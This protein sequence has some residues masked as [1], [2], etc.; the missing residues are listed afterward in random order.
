MGFDVE[1]PIDSFG[2]LVADPSWSPLR[3][4][5]LVT[6]DG[7]TENAWGDDGGTLDGAALF[8]VSGT[9]RMRLFAVCETI[10]AGGG[11]LE[12]GVTGSTA[13]LIAQTT[14]TDI[15]ANDIW[16]DNSPDAFVELSSVATE[17]IVANGL[18]VILTVSTD[19]I[20]SG[21]IRF[22]CSWYP[23]SAGASVIP[24]TN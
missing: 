20:T 23:I 6:F 9:V 10:I 2:K 3:C 12:V 15:D 1:Q 18:D 24:S 8:T 16:H 22:L 14:G 13:S 4:E 17:K 7:A 21:V 11:K 5:K 19:N